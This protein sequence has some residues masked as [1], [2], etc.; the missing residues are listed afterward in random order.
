AKQALAA[1]ASVGAA[2]ARAGISDPYYFSRLFRR[3]E[4]TTPSR[5]VERRRSE[6]PTT[7]VV[8]DQP[9]ADS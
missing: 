9:A 3:H 2:A 5:W 8:D 7:Y 6:L 1:G 4:R